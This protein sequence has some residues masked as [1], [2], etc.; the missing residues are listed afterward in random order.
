MTVQLK[1]PKLQLV[2]TPRLDEG[3]RTSE[4]MDEVLEK[5]TVRHLDGDRRGTE[6]AC[7]QGILWVTQEN[8]AQDYILHSG[9]SFVVTQRGR[10][11]IEVISDA[12][13]RLTPGKFMPVD[14]IKN[15]SLIGNN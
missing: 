13:L 6:I 3:I 14:T 10:V 12:I 15:R 2:E 11:V 8:D 1:N 5:L 4:S 9:D 7:L